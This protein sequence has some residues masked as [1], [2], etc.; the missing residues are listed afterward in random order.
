[1]CPRF[2]AVDFWHMLS[3]AKKKLEDI[4]AEDNFKLWFVPR[5]FLPLQK[6]DT[7]L[8]VF[9]ALEQDETDKAIFS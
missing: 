4:L 8:G 2:K 3:E 6:F 1:M 7:K 5:Q 9:G